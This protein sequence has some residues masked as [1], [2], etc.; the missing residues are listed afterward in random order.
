VKPVSFLWG[1]RSSVPLTTSAKGFSLDQEAP[2][3]VGTEIL[4]LGINAKLI[5]LA[6]MFLKGFQRRCHRF[7]GD[8]EVQCFE[9]I[10]LKLFG[11]FGGTSFGSFNWG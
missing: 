4:C 2:F 1:Q 8:K 6:S 11:C 5:F 7:F 3:L 10:W 9:G